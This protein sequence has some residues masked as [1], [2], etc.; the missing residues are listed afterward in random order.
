MKVPLMF[1]SVG[2]V[3]SDHL[4]M[5]PEEVSGKKIEKICL[6]CKKNDCA[7]VEGH[8]P[9]VPPSQELNDD[10]SPKTLGVNVSE[11]IKSGEAVG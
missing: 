6:E 9:S 2:M 5:L 8:A 10:G 3:C 7:H 4:P 11:K 1:T